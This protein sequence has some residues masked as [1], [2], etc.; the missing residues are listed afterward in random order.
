MPHRNDELRQASRL[1]S[2]VES[3]ARRHLPDELRQRAL[4]SLANVQVALAEGLGG[5]KPK[6]PR[7][8]DKY[9]EPVTPAEAPPWARPRG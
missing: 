8:A 4:G 7:S 3:I 5:L 6:E 9:F 1:L 2:A